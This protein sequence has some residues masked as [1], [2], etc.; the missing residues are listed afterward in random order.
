M[1]VIYT[2]MSTSY[3][4]SPALGALLEE[5]RAAFA[6]E[7]RANAALVPLLAIVLA[8]LSRLIAIHNDL[9]A[10]AAHPSRAR[11]RRHARTQA[12]SPHHAQ[13]T[14]RPD[15]VQT[16]LGVPLGALG[17]FAVHPSPTQVLAHPA[18]GP[19]KPPIRARRTEAPT[20]ALSIPKS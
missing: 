14:P 20:L 4:P 10:Q 2:F 11:T 3:T 6:A 5:L 7:A 13:A 18:R 19:P 16:A 1:L 17:A 8:C 15:S 9:T 12:P